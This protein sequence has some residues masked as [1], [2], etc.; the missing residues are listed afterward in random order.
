V[1]RNDQRHICASQL[2]QLRSTKSSDLSSDFSS[3]GLVPDAFRSQ[4]RGKVKPENVRRRCIFVNVVDPVVGRRSEGQLSYTGNGDILRTTR[5]R[6]PA[7]KKG[8]ERRRSGHSERH[9]VTRAIFQCCCPDQLA[10]TE[11]SSVVGVRWHSAR[12]MFDLRGDFVSPD[13]RAG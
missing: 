3:R 6:A 11:P 2:M 9:C 8:R 13:A 7:Q 4:S 12:G 10:F 5:G 1:E